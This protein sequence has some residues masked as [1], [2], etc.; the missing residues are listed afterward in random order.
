MHIA[1]YFDGQLYIQRVMEREDMRIGVNG[2]RQR[3]I[4]RERERER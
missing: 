2:G 3:E 4:V 1:V